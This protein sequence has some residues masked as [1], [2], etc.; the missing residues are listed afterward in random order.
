MFG[1]GNGIPV[2]VTQYIC[3]IILLIIAFRIV[4]KTFVLR[5][6]ISTSILSLFIGMLEFYFRSNP[7]LISEISL[8]VALGGICCGTGMG[9]IFT[10]NGSTGG[11]DIVAAMVSKLS[12]VSIGRTIIYVDMMIILSSLLLPFDGTLEERVKYRVPIIVYGFIV[13]YVM[14]YVTDMVI[15]TNRQ[16]VQFFIFSN[17]WQ[18]IADAVN[19]EARRGVTILDG[20][21]WYSKNNVKILMVWCRKIEAVTI[22]RIIKSVDEDAFI[23]QTNT[24]GVYGKGF[25]TM[26]VKIK[27]RKN[28]ELEN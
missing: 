11:T 23:T 26:K 22:H 27:P 8:S 6:V 4:G 9:M 24:N 14:A 5:T 3:N 7:P 28:E 18:E 1:V 10:H 13:T 16:A 17:K 21:G 15:N 2:S 25:D 12:N 19:R 20:Q